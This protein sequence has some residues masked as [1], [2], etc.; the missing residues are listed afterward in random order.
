[1]WGRVWT[2]LKAGNNYDFHWNITMEER[3]TWTSKWTR[4]QRGLYNSIKL[5]FKC[6]IFEILLCLNVYIIQ[7]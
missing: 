4:K 1:M 2:K 6:V 7:Q 3:V 5:V